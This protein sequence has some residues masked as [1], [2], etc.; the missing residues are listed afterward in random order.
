MEAREP[1][2]AYPVQAKD[3]WSRWCRRWSDR[4]DAIDHHLHR[5]HVAVEACIERRLAVHTPFREQPDVV[6]YYDGVTGLPTRRLFTTQVNHVLAAASREGR[7]VGVLALELLPDERG[8]QTQGSVQVDWVARVAAARFASVLGPRDSLGRVSSRQFTVL[9]CEAHAIGRMESVAGHLLRAVAAPL[10]IEGH[11]VRVACRVSVAVST[12]E[13]CLGDAL[14][15]RALE[16]LAVAVP[17]QVG[18]VPSSHG[19]PAFLS[20][21]PSQEQGFSLKPVNG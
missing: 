7:P 14:V 1:M 11:R 17:G 5:F 15:Q 19:L 3:M 20:L 2:L 21:T 12:P 10:M 8:T 16:A 18:P 13:L 4:M 9:V 6:A